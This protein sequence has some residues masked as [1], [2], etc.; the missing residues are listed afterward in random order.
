MKPVASPP[1]GSAVSDRRAFLKTAGVAAAVPFILP[2]GILSADVKLNDRINMGFIGMGKQ[3]RGLLNNFMRDDSVRAVAVAEVD[4]SRRDDSKN[5]VDKKYGNQDCK[6]YIDCRELIARDDIDAVCIA[7]PDHWHAYQTVAALNSGKDVYCE[8]P[9]THN[10]HESIAVIKA[11][12]RN[13]KIVQTGS[14]QRSSR[15]FRVAC[16]LVRNGVIGKVTRTAVNIGPPGIPCDLPE[17]E[18]EPGLD[19]DMWVGPGPLRPYNSVLS[20]RGVHNHFPNWR[21]YKEYGGGMVCDWGAHHIDIIHWGLGKDSSGPV[22]VIPPSENDGMKGAQLVYDGGISTVHGQGLG[23]QFV[24]TDGVVEVNRGVFTLSRKGKM[25]V[26]NPRNVNPRPRLN[27]ELD[28]AEEQYLKGAKVK[29]YQSSNHVQ[30]FLSCMRSRQQPIT[31]AET[32]ARTSIACHLMNQAYYNRQAI[33]WNPVRMKFAKG[34]GKAS[35][36]TR[37]YR[38]PWAVV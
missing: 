8:K 33:L 29:L 26:G 11:S 31:N 23:A 7:T 1:E 25:L 22:A 5:R 21:H 4:R 14:M 10:V 2:S 36:L 32:G 27:E 35:W 34:A 28:K 12:K 24:G 30:D 9:L 6:A 3:N 37:N 38:G 20:P 15:V 13:N 19:W 18:M 17:E 16:E